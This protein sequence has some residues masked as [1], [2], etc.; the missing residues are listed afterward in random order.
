MEIGAVWKKLAPELDAGV[1]TE[2]AFE[3]L[4]VHLLTDVAVP[5]ADASGGGLHKG[6]EKRHYE[7]EK[8]ETAVEHGAGVEW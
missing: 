7:E 2:V 3:V 8:A 4:T 5:E 6:G 1:G